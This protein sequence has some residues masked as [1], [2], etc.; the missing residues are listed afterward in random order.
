MATGDKIVNLDGLKAVYDSV[1]GRI[2]LV[3]PKN[4][5]QDVTWT[6]GKTIRSDTGA[7]RNSGAYRASSSIDVS[8]STSI[9]YQRC[10]TTGERT[11]SYQIGIAFYDSSSTFISD[12]GVEI[13]YASPAA[14]WVMHTVTVPEG[15]KYMRATWLNAGREEMTDEFYVFDADEYNA[16]MME[17]V[18]NT[19]QE[20][21]F[22]ERSISPVD[23]MTAA[24]AHANNSFVLVNG[25]LYRAT[26]AITAGQTISEHATATTIAAQLTALE[27][28]IAVLEAAAE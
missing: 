8:G 7:T 19:R 17:I 20:F 18:L 3:L 13:V 10:C 5:A 14:G 16:T 27:T 22:V 9:V 11:T 28:R 12:S 4:L 2:A 21:N 15:A 26:E 1:D 24:N 23:S 6:D 25:T